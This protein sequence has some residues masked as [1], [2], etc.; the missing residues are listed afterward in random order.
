MGQVGVQFYGAVMGCGCCGAVM[1]SVMGCWC[2]SL[3]WGS[4]PPPPPPY[5]LSFPGSGRIRALGSSVPRSAGT[6]GSG[7]GGGVQL[8]VSGLWG[9]SSGP[10]CTPPPK[11]PPCPPQYPHCPP[12]NIPFTPPQISPSPPPQIPLLPPPNIPFTPPQI[13]PLPTQHPS[14]APIAASPIL[15]SFWG[16]GVL[17]LGGGSGGRVVFW[18]GGGSNGDIG[19]GLQ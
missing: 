6:P 5:P 10:H 4:H 19:E 7:G 3:G 17:L 16:G 11:Y 14:I 18:E 15:H 9:G 8:H 2:R 1:G 13:S 12:P